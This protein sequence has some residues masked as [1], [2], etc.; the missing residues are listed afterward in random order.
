[1]AP[2]QY[3]LAATWLGSALN[4][5]DAPFAIS[6]GSKLL[7]TVRVNQQRAASTFTDGGASWQNLGT[8]TI[9]G[10]TLTVKLSSSLSGRVMADAIRLERVDSTSGGRVP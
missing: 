1:L 8:V 4:A 2:G 5:T 10:N 9:T 6:S 3:R 7:S